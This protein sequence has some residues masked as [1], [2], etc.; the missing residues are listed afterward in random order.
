MT[1]L[2]FLVE[3]GCSLTWLSHYS[4]LTPAECQLPSFKITSSRPGA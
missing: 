1:C 2:F 3:F 4:G